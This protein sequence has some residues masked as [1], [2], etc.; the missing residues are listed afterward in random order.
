MGKKSLSTFIPFVTFF[1]NTFFMN[2]CTC[3]I[4]SQSLYL[5]YLKVP[6]A[7]VLSDPSKV[8]KEV[9]VMKREN[10]RQNFSFQR[11]EDKKCFRHTDRI[12]EL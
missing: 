7:Q 6:T 4:C 9:D 8:V 1:F 2:N 3:T 11:N 5:I 10:S 12:T